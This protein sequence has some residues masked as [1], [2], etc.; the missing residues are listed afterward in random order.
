MA[1]PSLLGKVVR[2]QEKRWMDRLKFAWILHSLRQATP[3]RLLGVSARPRSAQAS[4]VAVL[5]FVRRE[6]G[7]GLPQ[8]RELV[9]PES[10]RSESSQGDRRGGDLELAMDLERL[11]RR[12]R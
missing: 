4:G 1:P 9:G 2:E 5:A 8:C 7:L 6:F 12:N 10:L 3:R 11:K